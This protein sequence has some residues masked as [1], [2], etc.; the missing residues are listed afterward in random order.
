MVPVY[1]ERG[2]DA[3]RGRIGR[4]AAVAKLIVTQF[5]AYC[6]LEYTLAG[7]AKELK[8]GNLDAKLNWGHTR[9]NVQGMRL[10]LQQDTPDDYVV[11]TEKTYS[12]RVFCELVCFTVGLNWKEF[13]QVD[14]L[15]YRPAEM[16]LLMADA[17]TAK[18]VLKRVPP[19]NF[20]DLVPEM[21]HSNPY[22]LGA[23]ID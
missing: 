6:A 18:D 10:M 21:L 15:F 14:H 11:A 5:G 2:S 3:R 19:V 9:D 20:E 8:L 16:D 17:A 13:V 22:A 1:L 7:Q 12:V 4:P 23:S